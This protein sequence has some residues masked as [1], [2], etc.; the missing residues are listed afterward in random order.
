MS[1]TRNVSDV[2]TVSG[3]HV[4]VAFCE[5]GMML[6]LSVLLISSLVLGYVSYHIVEFFKVGWA[7]G[8]KTGQFKQFS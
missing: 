8:A 3:A 4:M 6:A 1:T 2:Q 7:M 5:F